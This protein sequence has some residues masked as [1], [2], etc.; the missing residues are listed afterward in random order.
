MVVAMRGKGRPSLVEAGEI[1]RAIRDAALK[2]LLEQGEAAT[3]N[4]IALAAGLSRKSLYARFPNKTELFLSVIRDL[5]A[6]VS[7]LEYDD[8]ESAEDRLLHYVRAALAVIA[9]PHSQAFQRLLTLDAQYTSALRGE[10]IE[11]SRKLFVA[12]LAD[13]LA[14][15]KRKNQFDVE[16]VDATALAITRLIFAESMSL[17]RDGPP[18]DFDIYA[19]FITRLIARG[20]MPRGT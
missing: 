19:A 10:M 14:D 5:L 12:P 17:G 3:M 13:L 20:L 2:V 18:A 6:G 7:S 1:D 8:G 4:A 16:D 11:A 9:R 15:A